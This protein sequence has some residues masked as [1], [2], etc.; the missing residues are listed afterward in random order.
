MSFKCNF[1]KKKMVCDIDIKL[2]AFDAD[3]TLWDNQSYFNAVEA[4]Y[5][6]LLAGYGTADEISSALFSVETANMPL[7][8]YGGKAFTISL[9]ENAVNVSGGKVSAATILKIIG[10]GK[11]LLDLQ[12]RPL[13]GVAET[14]GKIQASGRYTMVVFTKGEILDQENKL[15]RSGLSRF[16]DDV[17]V[18]ADKTPREYMRLCKRFNVDISNMLMVG[19]SFKSDIEPVLALGGYAVHIPFH[20]MWKHEVVKEHDHERLF[21]LK[22]FSELIQTLN[23]EH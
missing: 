3:D 4:E 8:G 11:S 5:C 2:L 20:T 15:R 10:L 23:F 13:P 9:V 22:Q 6:R 1:E 16:F 17:V 19:N 14:L 21:R 12:S 18:V 7:L